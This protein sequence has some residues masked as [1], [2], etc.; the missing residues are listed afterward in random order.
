MDKQ[1]FQSHM[2]E[3]IKQYP[4][5]GSVMIPIHGRTHIYGTDAYFQCRLFPATRVAEEMSS[6][7]TNNWHGV[8]PGFT[9]YGYGDD[10]DTIYA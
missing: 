8:S 10:T 6:D 2:L 9:R 3:F 7:D 4:N 1:I 5:T